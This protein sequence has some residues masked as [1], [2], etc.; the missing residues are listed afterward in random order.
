MKRREFITL[1]GGVTATWPLNVRAQQSDRIRQVGILLPAT[2][3]NPEFQGEI[4][5]FLHELSR[6]GWTN[7][8]NVQ[9]ETRWATTNP[10]EIRKQAAELAAL[11]PDVIV[12][13]GTSTVGPMM[14]ATK[15][16]PIVFPIAIDPLGAGFVASLSRPGGSVTGF[17]T[18]EY[19]LSG[20][21]EDLHFHRP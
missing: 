8:V 6:L 12:A 14:Q 13:H 4:G 3:D 10:A 7:G 9:I 11:A 16:V 2:A 20:P 15:T 18:F 1:L 21:F 5:A 19:S 17:L